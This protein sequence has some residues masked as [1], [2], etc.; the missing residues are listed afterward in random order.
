MVGLHACNG[1]SIDRVLVTD[2]NRQHAASLGVDV[3]VDQPEPAGGTARDV[4]LDAREPRQ[5]TADMSGSEKLAGYP[6]VGKVVERSTS[7]D[8]HLRPVDGERG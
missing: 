8:H 7:G 4:E 6:S 3:A 2:A 1:Q 5:V